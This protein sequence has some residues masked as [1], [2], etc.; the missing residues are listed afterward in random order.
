MDINYQRIFVYHKI[1]PEWPRFHIP[2]ISIQWLLFWNDADADDC[3]KLL[4]RLTSPFLFSCATRPYERG[5]E[6]VWSDVQERSGSQTSGTPNASGT[7][8]AYFGESCKNSR[9]VWSFVPHPLP[10]LRDKCPF[11]TYRKYPLIQLTK[12]WDFFARSPTFLFCYTL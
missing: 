12:P 9:K 3:K 10:P 8:V 1:A 6:Q 2:W 11:I 4:K 5:S 7:V